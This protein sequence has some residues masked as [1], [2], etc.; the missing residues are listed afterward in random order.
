MSQP[1][2]WEG[3]ITRRLQFVRPEMKFSDY[4]DYIAEGRVNTITWGDYILTIKNG[5][6]S[7]LAARDGELIEEMR[8]E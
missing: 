8:P 4:T 7:E 5:V 1:N 3:I 2:I 6:Y